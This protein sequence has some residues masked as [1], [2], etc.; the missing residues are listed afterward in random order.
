MREYRESNSQPQTPVPTLTPNPEINPSS[1]KMQIRGWGV[2]PPAAGGGGVRGTGFQVRKRVSRS[3]FGVT[4]G[5]ELIEGSWTR[6]VPPRPRRSLLIHPGLEGGRQFALLG[7]EINL[8]KGTHSERIP[9][10]LNQL[11]LRPRIEIESLLPGLNHSG[12][13]NV[14][15]T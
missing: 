5:S 7:A 14:F 1:C 6:S 2:F 15:W 11:I 9:Q 8:E 10:S 4:V 3:G 12:P 13:Q